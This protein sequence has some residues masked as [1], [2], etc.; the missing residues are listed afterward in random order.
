M[1]KL[2]IVL[3]VIIFIL[4]G[5]LIFVQ[6]AKSPTVPLNPSPVS[7]QPVISP[8]GKVSIFSPHPNDK[9][10]SPLI[11]QGTVTGG[12]W[13][14]EAVFPV[15]GLDGNGTVLGSGQAQAQSD[16]MATAAV[17]F[18]ATITFTAPKFAAGTLILKKDNPSGLPQNDG[19][20]RI[21]VRFGAR[22]AQ[23][24]QC[25]A[26][27]CSKEVC[28]DQD[29]VTNCIFLPQ[30][31]CYKTARCERQASGECGWTTTPELRNCLRSK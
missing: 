13:F 29:V 12:G 25:R 7:L 6:P 24:S 9:V 20:L 11:V 1:K 17:P 18:T 10:S 30:Y 21:P 5:I 15:E 16:W 26:T 19:E 4:L 27:G 8:D 2:V 23:A 31:S 3:A 22:A 14:F 28:S